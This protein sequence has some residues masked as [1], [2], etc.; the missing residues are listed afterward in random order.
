MDEITG[1]KALQWRE[2]ADLLGTRQTPAYWSRP[3][4]AVACGPGSVDCL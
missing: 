3:W 4:I 2:I 1:S